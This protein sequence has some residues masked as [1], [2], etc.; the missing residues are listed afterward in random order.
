M[1]NLLA[2]IFGCL[3]ALSLLEIFLRLYHPFPVMVKQNDI[4]LP[5]NRA[6]VFENTHIEKLDTHITCTK[7]ELGFRGENL[8]TDLA[9]VTSIIAVGGSTTE[10]RLLNDG[11]DWPH[12]VHKKL[13]A[14]FP[15]E[16]IWMNNGGIDGHS[17]FGH[18]ILLENYLC[19]MKPDYLL[20][21]TGINEMGREDLFSEDQ[22]IVRSNSFSLTDWV[23]KNSETFILANNLYRSFKA[24]QVD[25]AHGNLDLLKLETPV[26]GQEEVDSLFKAHLPYIAAYRER[27]EKVVSKAMACGSSPI[28][29]TQPLLFGNGTDS[30]TGVDLGK[31]VTKFFNGQTYWCLLEEYNDATRNTALELNLPLIDLARWMPKDSRY[32][33]DAMH[34]TN[35]GSEVVSQIVEEDL[36]KIVFNG[37]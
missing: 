26:V 7:N 12:L 32:F 13:Q 8:P 19:E 21:L 20:F 1:N 4:L 36:R 3:L 2:F 35:E 33:Y 27:L 14:H 6:F 10:C 5:A 15:K 30:L 22:A 29:I 28:L 9:S 31:V 16:K 18:L 37:N 24:Y 23:K 17:T 11:H 25:L 34:F